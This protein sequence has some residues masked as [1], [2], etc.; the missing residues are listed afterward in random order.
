MKPTG[1]YVGGRPL[2]GIPGALDSTL[3]LQIKQNRKERMG[4]REGAK[5]KA[6]AGHGNTPV[7]PA[8]GGRG[9]RIRNSLLASVT[10]FLS[11]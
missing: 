2:A 3:V 4:R 7:I 1:M 8:L 11:H 9:R 10:H 6:K 5:T